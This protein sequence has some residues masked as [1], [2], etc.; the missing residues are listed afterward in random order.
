MKIRGLSHRPYHDDTLDEKAVLDGIDIALKLGKFKIPP[1]SLEGV[2][3]PDMNLQEYLKA[4]ARIFVEQISQVKPLHDPETCKTLHPAIIMDRIPFPAQAHTIQGLVEALKLENLV[5][6][7]ADMGTGKSLISIGVGNVMYHNRNKMPTRVLLS[8]PGVTIP[9]WE[10]VE[11]KETLPDAT[12]TIIRSTNDAAHYLRQVRDKTLPD[13]LNFVL[14]GIDRAKLGPDLWCIA[15]WKRIIEIEGA[16]DDSPG[17]AKAKEHAW[18]CPSCGKWLP[19]PRAEKDGEEI[20]AGWTLFVD[21]PLEKGMFNAS[22]APQ[23]KIKW[24][25]PPRLRKCPRC[26]EPLWRPA[27]KSRGETRNAPRWYVSDIFKRLGKHF[28]LYIA[29]EIHQS[30]A[31][32]SG[33]GFAFAQMVKSARKTMAMTGTLLNG[34]STSLKEILWRTDPASL[35]KLGFDHQTGMVTWASR[36]GVLERVTRTSEDDAGVVTKRKKV[37]RQPKEKP[38]IAPELIATH[39]LHRSVFMDLQDL[40]LPLVEMKEIPE[41]VDLDV[42]H[43]DSYKS[44]HTTLHSMCKAAYA[45]GNKGAFARFI[46][47]TINAVDRSDLDHIVHVGKESLKFS[48]F[49]EDYF[50]AKELKLVDI[51]RENLAENR[52]IVIYTFYTG[53]YSVHARLKKVLRAHGIDSEILESSTSTEERFEWLQNA[54]DR[55]SKVLICNLRLVEV[56][57]DLLAWPTLIFYEMSYDIN[58]V[59]QASRRAWRIGQMRESRVYYLVANSTQQIAQFQSCMSKRAHAMLAEG[60]LDRSDLAKFGRDASNALAV[61]L[62]GCI[63]R[64]G[65]GKKWSLLA[66]KDMGLETVSEEKF[67]EVLRVARKKLTNQTLL[68]CGLAPEDYEDEEPEVVSTKVA[69]SDLYTAPKRRRKPKVAL[70]QMS[71]FDLLGIAEVAS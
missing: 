44:F 18:H 5:V 33:R 48:G 42:M 69:W 50:N 63:D 39:L 3:H 45:R 37:K 51:V 28:H 54:A 25:M 19:D 1:S 24:V 56:G 9:K 66:E 7:A 65:L 29:D 23:Q 55:G 31:E 46:P 35:L 16:S 38:G 60:K 15:Q 40:E 2:F 10:N 34:M 14:V 64:D 13:G 27:L 68:L 71:L 17:K 61:D 58:S 20:P 12:V 41:F 8:A 11:I 4:N 36:Y 21:E 32:D 57:L 70:G 6:C 49:G 52:G 62:A 67:K 53:I 59:R 43:L 47:A 26:K 30:K 22:G